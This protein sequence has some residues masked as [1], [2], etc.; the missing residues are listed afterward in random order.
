MIPVI[1]DEGS[2][3][4]LCRAIWTSEAVLRG[5]ECSH[6]ADGP[7]CF[8]CSKETE[9]LV[10]AVVSSLGYSRKIDNA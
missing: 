4:T 6:G 1:Y 2:F 8:S 9:R 3:S 10:I 7:D 5:G